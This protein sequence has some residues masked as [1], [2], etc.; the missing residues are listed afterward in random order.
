[1]NRLTA[2]K[3]DAFLPLNNCSNN[4]PIDGELFVR[5]VDNPGFSSFLALI[6]CCYHNS[7]SHNLLVR[8]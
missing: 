2:L 4:L 8:P 6:I 7:H 1:M 5:T 3:A